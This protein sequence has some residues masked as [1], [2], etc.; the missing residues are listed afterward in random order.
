MTTD[1]TSTGQTAVATREPS[2]TLSKLAVSVVIPCY[3]EEHRVRDEITLVHEKLSSLDLAAFEIVAVNDGSTDQTGAALRGIALPAFRMVDLPMN[4]GYGAALKSGIRETIYP[5]VLI[6]DADGTYPV[7]AIPELLARADRAEMVVGAR[8]GQNV[9][10]PLMR[11]PAKWCI[12]QLANYLSGFHIPDLNSGL[13]L[14]R[15]DI[16]D[17]FEPIL[18]E[19]FSFT[20][21]ITL[22]MLTNGYQVDYCPINYARRQ[23]KSKI[24]PIADALNFIQLIVRTVTYFRPLKV[25]VPVS[26]LLFLCFVVLF[27]L[28]IARG[29]G[30]L[31]TSVMLL[32]SS[33]QVLTAG[34]LA[35]LI[36]RRTKL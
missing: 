21:T 36:T 27:L 2:A 6:T 5:W 23:G 35:D 16:V 24:R 17:R 8:D 29:G 15:R 12:N 1:Q 14:M 20:T 11:R 28:R 18:P 19:G 32:I 10:V 30:F 25:F 7:D 13:R 22:A 26:S 4:R 3:N 31:G 33:I 34:M 9:N